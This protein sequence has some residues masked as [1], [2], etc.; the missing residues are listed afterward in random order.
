MSFRAWLN[1]CL[2]RPLHLV[3]VRRAA[4]LTM[5]RPVVSCAAGMSV[6]LMVSLLV[7]CHGPRGAK[8]PDLTQIATP[9]SAVTSPALEATNTPPASTNLPPESVILREG[10]T[11]R[12]TFPESANLNTVQQ[13]R[14]DGKI[15]LYL[16]GEFKAAGF[17]LSGLQKELLKLYE[18]QLVSKEINVTLESSAFFVFVTGAVARPGRLSFDRPLT[19]LQAVIDA[20]VEH[21]KAN[22]KDVVVIRRQGGREERYHL[23]LRLELKGHG[24]EP[25]WLQPSDIVFVRERFTWF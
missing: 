12:I 5:L 14:R 18:P 10:D 9:P 19:A 22:L 15:S 20:G 21:S 11:V 7:G 4:T 23:N 13:I 1:H 8:S 3:F 6:L 17:T 24:S 16:V 25:F 2:K